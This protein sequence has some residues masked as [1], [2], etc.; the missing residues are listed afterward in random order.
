MIKSITIR[1]RNG[2]RMQ[3]CL[4]PVMMVG[5]GRVENIISCPSCSTTYNWSR[6]HNTM[7]CYM[8]LIGVMLAAVKCVSQHTIPGQIWPCLGDG[9]IW[10]KYGS[11]WPF[12]SCCRAPQGSYGTGKTGKMGNLTGQIKSGKQTYKWNGSQQSAYLCQGPL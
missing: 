8:W 4:T 1:N 6:Y 12:R 7:T 2:E 3:P 11:D 10:V 9:R 5:I